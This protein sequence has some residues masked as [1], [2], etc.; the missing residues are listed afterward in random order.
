[1]SEAQLRLDLRRRT[2]N[3]PQLQ[4]SYLEWNSGGEPLL[5]LHGLADCGAVWLSLA[6]DLSD[7]YHCIAPDLRGHGDSSKP[8]RG[9]GCQD[10]IADL[11]ALMEN[12][13]WSEAHVVGHSWSAKVAAVWAR[14]QPERFRSLVLVDPFFIDRLPGWMTFTFP[15]LYRVLPFL[16][17]VGSFD[18]YEQAQEQAQKLKQYRGW[19]QFQEMVFQASIEKKPNGKWGSKFVKQ[20]RNEIFADVMRV[21][22]LT[23]PIDVPTLFLQP[24]T[25]LNRTAWQLKPYRTYLKNLEIRQI[26]GNHWAFLVEPKAFNQTVA[27]FLMSHQLELDR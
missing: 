2:L 3:L 25:G 15:L 1:M 21:A 17:L 5:L 13:G 10:I 27:A 6:E 14:Q 11:E 26:P 22:G 12:L 19:S 16:K 8:D 20:A 23:E 18:S 24:E 7:R 4:L 9:Y